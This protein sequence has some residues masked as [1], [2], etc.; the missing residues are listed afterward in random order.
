L[1]QQASSIVAR[2]F[3]TVE[4]IWLRRIYV[5]VFIE[6]ATRRASSR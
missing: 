1:A 2:D 4:T 5:L 3:F 6:L